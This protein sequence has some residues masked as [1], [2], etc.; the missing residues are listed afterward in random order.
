MFDSAP[1]SIKKSISRSGVLKFFISWGFLNR[2]GIVQI[3]SLGCSFLYILINVVCIQ[4]FCF[5]IF[6]G[7]ICSVNSRL[8]LASLVW[9]LWGVV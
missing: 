5:G 6:I 1:E 9:N 8:F 7:L 2:N 4:A 3:F